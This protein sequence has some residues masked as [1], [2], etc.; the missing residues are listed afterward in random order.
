MAPGAI[1][2]DH[3]ESHAALGR[4]DARANSIQNA[5]CEAW[6]TLSPACHQT[7]RQTQCR[8]HGR[9]AVFVMPIGQYLDGEQF[10]P[11]TARLLG[12]AFEFAIQALH[13]WG[14]VDPPRDAIA[15]AIIGFARAGERA[16]SGCA[17]SP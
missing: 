5:G 1:G 11:E 17:I 14:V 12:I 15:R 7:L 8:S 3:S 16:L 13:N 2:H 9:I 4:A 10:D 6:M